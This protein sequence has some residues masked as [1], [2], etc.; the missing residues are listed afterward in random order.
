MFA[1]SAAQ[2]EVVKLL[3]DNKADPNFHKGEAS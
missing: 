3:L 1:C 2:V